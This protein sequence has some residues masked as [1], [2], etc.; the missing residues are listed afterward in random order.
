MI[1]IKNIAKLACLLIFLT[2][3]GCNTSSEKNILSLAEKSLINSEK[4]LQENSKQPG[5][6]Q[7]SS[8]LQ[9]KKLKNGTGCHPNPNAPVT[10][11]YESRL[12]SNNIPF[13]SSY[14]RN[15][16]ATYDLKRMILAWEEGI[17][18]MQEGDIFEFYVHPNLAYGEKGALPVIQPNVITIYKVELIKAHLCQ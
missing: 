1:L 14:L 9:Y 11:H 10:V 6:T 13:D 2:V 12:L 7:T 4:F 15:Q 16:A 3:V 18:L 17:P 5:I 8:G